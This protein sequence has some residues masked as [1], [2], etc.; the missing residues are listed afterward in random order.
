MA[1][2]SKDDWLRPTQLLG[3]LEM[4][5]MFLCFTAAFLTSEFVPQQQFVKGCV[6]S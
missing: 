3:H 4:I 6:L 1:V 5:G 2:D